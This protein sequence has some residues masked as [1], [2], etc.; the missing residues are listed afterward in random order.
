MKI[1]FLQFKPQFGNVQ[2][3]IARIEK[4]LVGEKFDLI[5][6]PELSNSG[7]LF[8]NRNEVENFSEEVGEG[9]F[10]RM[11]R[12]IAF[13]KNS[14][15]IAGLCEKY[16]RGQSIKFF[17]SALLV[18]PKGDIF[19]YRKI[20][21]F[22]E[23]SKWFFP[24][25]IPFTVHTIKGVFGTVKIGLMLCFDW[26]FPEA[27][28]TLA[29]KGSQIICH[30]SNLVMPY[31]QK[32][33]FTRAV[34]NRVFIITANR[35]GAETHKSKKLNFTGNSVIV[36]PKGNYL[37]VGSRQKEEIRIVDIDPREALSKKVDSG[38]D[39]FKERRAQFYFLK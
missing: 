11:L 13:E 31:C 7:Y 34:E 8:T 24:G 5:V 4:L 21:L 25:N 32:A 17:N 26:I 15:I 18:C 33:M 20:H 2:N 39:V 1:G 37:A 19:V 16:K 23:E 29:L 27:A 9:I 35:V 36:D 30:P 14:Y 10:S 12:K 38:N 6:L 22:A 28:R 3:N